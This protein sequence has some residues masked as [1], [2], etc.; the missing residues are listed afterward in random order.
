MQARSPAPKLTRGLL[1][2]VAL[3]VLTGGIP[4]AAPRSTSEAQGVDYVPGQLWVK[5]QRADAA[6]HVL[7]ATSRWQTRIVGQ[8]AQLGIVALRVPPGQELQIAA[9]LRRDVLVQYVELEHR[10]QAQDDPND[11][12][13]PEQWNLRKVGSQQ[14]WDTTHCQGTLIAFIDTGCYLDH[15]DLR[16][17]LWTNPG[18]IPDNGIDDDGNGKVDDIHGWHFFHLYNGSTTDS[19]ED[20]DVGDR[21]GHGTHVVGIAAAQTSNGIGV[22]SMSWGARAMIVRALDDQGN[23]YYTDVALGIIYAVDNGARVINLSLGGEPQDRVLEDAVNYAYQKGA[24]LVAAAG[25]NGTSVYYPAAYDHVMAVA[26]TASD[27]Q[28]AGFS[29]RGPQVDVAAP[30][31]SI[32]STWLL[33]YLYWGNGN[34]GEKSGT[35][36]ATP[37][38]SG[39]AALLWSWRTDWS[40]DQIELRLEQTADDVN[41]TVLPGRDDELG[42]GRLNV[43][44]ALHDLAPGPTLT[45]TRTAMPTA[46]PTATVT[47]TST[48]TFTTTPSPTSAPTITPT[49]QRIWLPLIIRAS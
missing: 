41:A 35:S 23:G 44:R 34:P 25:N 6:P 18:E 39:A 28:R 38:V 16:N 1:L 48:A 32:L 15:P 17:A 45:P 46:S 12:R 29:N 37:H 3:I 30:G 36:M 7:A 27:D 24:L 42:W 19:Y 9:E 2:V 47:R 10:L 21:N 33:P 14:A 31:V 49:I 22:A 26:A 13:W 43:G 5:L 20:L 11:Q 8:I 40:N 4:I